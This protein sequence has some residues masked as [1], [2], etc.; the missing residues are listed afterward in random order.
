MELIP[1]YEILS[2]STCSCS[3]HL[4]PSTYAKHATDQRY[5][6]HKAVELGD[7]S[8][9]QSLLSQQ[10]PADRAEYVNT[11]DNK[12]DTPLHKAC[13]C[14]KSVDAVKLCELLINSGAKIDTQNGE[15]N[16]RL[17][18]SVWYDKIDYDYPGVSLFLNDYGDNGETDDRGE[19]TPLHL[20]ASMGHSE[21]AQLLLDRGAT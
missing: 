4:H 19:K 12:G 14:E 5:P 18:K 13:F 16:P 21:I 7:L 8:T 15:G 1:K 20:A 10:N 3:N 11:T 2:I 6:L 9:A 17:R